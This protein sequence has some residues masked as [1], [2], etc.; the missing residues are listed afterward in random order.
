MLRVNRSVALSNYVL[1][2]E[3]FAVMQKMDMGYLLRQ[4]VLNALQSHEI[5]ELRTRFPNHKILFGG[6][7]IRQED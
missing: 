1:A 6:N 7:A 2:M 4:E 3:Q 5:A